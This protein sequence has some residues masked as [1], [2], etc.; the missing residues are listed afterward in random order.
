VNA[1]ERQI[2]RLPVKQLDT[3]CANPQ[4]LKQARHYG[5]PL[6]FRLVAIRVPLRLASRSS[7]SST[8]HSDDPR[9]PPAHSGSFTRSSAQQ[10]DSP[11]EDFAF[12][13]CPLKSRGRRERGGY[14]RCPATAVD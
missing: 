8:N 14:G 13:Q 11:N 12:E 9:R 3:G 6:R 4:L 5:Q 1:S 10:R 7:M 2:R